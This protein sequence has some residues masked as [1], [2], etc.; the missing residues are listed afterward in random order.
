VNLANS[1]WSSAAKTKQTQTAHI[2]LPFERENAK[3]K[4]LNPFY[5]F[6]GIKTKIHIWNDNS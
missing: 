4:D 6:L 1:I 3:L 2:F 5:F